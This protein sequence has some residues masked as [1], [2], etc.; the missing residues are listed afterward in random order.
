MVVEVV[1]SGCSRKVHKTCTFSITNIPALFEEL[2][3]G[4]RPP[5]V[6][7]RRRTE[8]R[9]HC[10]HCHFCS[11]HFVTICPYQRIYC[12]GHG[13]SG[14]GKTPGL[15]TIYYRHFCCCSCSTSCRLQRDRRVFFFVPT[16]ALSSSIHDIFVYSYLI[17]LPLKKN[18][19]CCR[20][21]S[22]QNQSKERRG[23]LCELVFP[24]SLLPCV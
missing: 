2:Y 13:G 12:T 1:V 9:C 3:R 15:T 11:S 22:N 5:P 7:T 4:L 19:P 14:E 18:F 6:L 8:R 23:I 20:S 16:L 24:F 17:F 21:S 10:C